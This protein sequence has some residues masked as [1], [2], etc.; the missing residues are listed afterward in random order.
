MNPA[1]DEHPGVD[2]LPAIK[3]RATE[4]PDPK[5]RG[6]K[7]HRK[8]R[9]VL[10]QFCVSRPPGVVRVSPAGRFLNEKSASNSGLAKKYPCT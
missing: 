1:E 4:R 2:I 6:K 5:G 7:H 3:E 9:L 10:R 8:R